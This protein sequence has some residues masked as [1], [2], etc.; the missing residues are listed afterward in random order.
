MIPGYRGAYIA[1]SVARL[2]DDALLSAG[3]DVD[4]MV[5]GDAAAAGE[6]YAGKTFQ[7]GL[8]VEGTVIPASVALDT[9]AA[10]RDYHLAPGIV[11]ARIL[12]DPDGEIARVREAVR[13]RYADLDTIMARLDHVEERA[14]ATLAAATASVTDDRSEAERIT[15][16]QF[17]VGQIAH[18]VLVAALEN[19][20][21]RR[22]YIAASGVLGRFGEEIA[23]ERLLRLAH[24]NRIGLPAVAALA[25]E[26][27]ALLHVAGPV[28]DGSDWRFASD[29]A[30]P[31]RPVVMDGIRAMTGEGWHREA[32]FWIAATWCRC[33]QLLEREAPG[34][35]PPHQMARLRE[36][37][38]VASD[39]DLR[40]AVAEAVEA[41]PAFREIAG[42]IASQAAD[43]GPGKAV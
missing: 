41:I 19:P 31:I 20:T 3:S 7:H 25:R 30:T 26:L 6:G 27:E 43:S 13:A 35:L 16:W 32:M 1:G 11:H 38:H 2:P 10:L 33:A 14:R 22:R 17:G 40:N 8:V 29:I 39:D 28:A 15:A 18:M 12:D 23:Y 24:V 36:H 5:V 21:V 34:T 37:L 9:G 4:V 42:R